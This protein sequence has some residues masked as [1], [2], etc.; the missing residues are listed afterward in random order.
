[1]LDSSTLEVPL[2]RTALMVLLCLATPSAAHATDEEESGDAE[3]M[4]FLDNEKAEQHRK[5]READRAPS[6]EDFLD[7]EDDDGPMMTIKGGA[8]AIEDDDIDDVDMDEPLRLGTDDPDMDED[9][10]PT[11]DLSAADRASLMRPL[12]DNYPLA[13]VA[14][15]R[16]QV[17]VELP[18]LVAQSTGD[19][20]GEDY[21]VIA[22][23][24]VNGTVTSEGQHL[25]TQRGISAFGPTKVWFKL[26]A[27]LEG[28]E[29]DVQVKVSKRMGKSSRV[30]P[31]FSRSLT[32]GM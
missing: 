19:F 29:S 17:T 11:E 31:L 4:D 28:P 30:T 24:V 10:D 3:E 23:V 14:R 6:G 21:W 12:A 32:I 25:V 2:T 27:P 9:G 5:A 15:T 16:G 20:G 18:V 1:M 8:P 13:M 26:E 22:Q 7:D